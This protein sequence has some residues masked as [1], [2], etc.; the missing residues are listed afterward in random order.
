[1]DVGLDGIS[2]ELL[3]HAAGPIRHGLHTLFGKIWKSGQVDACRVRLER[4][5][6][7]TNLRGEGIK[8]GNAPVTG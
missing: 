3:R 4:W 2:P 1:M 6:H 7:H 8:K 5:R